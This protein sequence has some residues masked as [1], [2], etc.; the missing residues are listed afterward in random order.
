MDLAPI[1]PGP[2][3]CHTGMETCTD[4]DLGSCCR[5]CVSSVRIA[6][7]AGPGDLGV[8]AHLRYQALA[9]T[10]ACRDRGGRSRLVDFDMHLPL[11]E[12]FR[13]PRQDLG[14]RQLCLWEGC[15]GIRCIRCIGD[16]NLPQASG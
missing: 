12:D 9:L 6:S 15:A 11:M 7:E 5:A 16:Q 4:P 13:K 3:Q 10:V 2:P 8:V 14:S 1:G